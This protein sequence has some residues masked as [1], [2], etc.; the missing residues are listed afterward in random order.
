MCH[1]T[2][3]V[4]VSTLGLAASPSVNVSSPPCVYV[5]VRT[6]VRVC[7]HVRMCVRVRMC[8]CM[9]GRYAGTLPCELA[10]P[11]FSSTL[12]HSCY[13]PPSHSRYSILS[14][15]T[16][17]I[18][19]GKPVFCK[20]SP[21]LS[22][23][24]SSPSSASRASCSLF[25]HLPGRRQTLERPELPLQVPAVHVQTARLRPGA[26]GQLAGRQ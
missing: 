1:P 10:L 22:Q 11:L 21:V 17:L 26:G 4:H 16:L 2:V 3:C 18:P 15:M 23:L 13:L 14:Q 8:A 25:R 5:C 12:P 19:E 6:R 7:V 9:C 24:Y 20:S